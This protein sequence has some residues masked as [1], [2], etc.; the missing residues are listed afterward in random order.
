VLRLWASLLALLLCASSLGEAAH[1]LLVQHRVCAEHGELIEVHEGEAGAE[2]TA[3]DHEHGTRASAPA[4]EGEHQHCQLLGR[5]Q[6]ELTLPE[7]AAVPG[8]SP[9]P[10]AARAALH[11]SSIARTSQS[12]LSLAPKTSPPALAVG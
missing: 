7:V 5:R 11:D 8:V 10:V 9:A 1:F 6:Q 12:A 4:E 2:P 3:S